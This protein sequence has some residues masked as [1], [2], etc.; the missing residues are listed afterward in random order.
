M[1]A[2]HEDEGVKYACNQCEK[3]FRQQGNLTTHIQFIK[4]MIASV[5][6]AGKVSIYAS[7]AAYPAH[8]ICF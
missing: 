8:N 5:Y 6:P 3:Q 2:I 7:L 1:L 4:Y